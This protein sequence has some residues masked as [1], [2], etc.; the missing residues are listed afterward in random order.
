MEP[1][2]QTVVLISPESLFTGEKMRGALASAISGTT[3][4]GLNVL[5]VAVLGLSAPASAVIFTFLTGSMMSYVLDILIAKRTF[6]RSPNAEAVPYLD[7]GRRFRWLFRSFGRR[8]FFRFVITV[9][10]ETLTG[11]AILR[12]AIRALDDRGILTGDSVRRY[13]DV[14]AAILSAVAVFALFGNILRFDWA[15]V[16]DE[17]PILT[18]VVLMWMGVTLLV[19]SVGGAL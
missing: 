17:H 1:Q 9:I 3:A 10:I 12:A 13:R 15:Y 6:G 11:L 5:G 14:G 8:F 7:L 18:M 16:E 4:N 19:F 2:T